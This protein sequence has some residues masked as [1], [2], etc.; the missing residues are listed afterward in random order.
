M[1][2]TEEE[3]L[4]ILE[5]APGPVPGKEIRKRLEFSEK[6]L[7]LCIE[8]LRALGYRVTYHAPSALSLDGRPDS[9]TPLEIRAGF[10]TLIVGKELCCFKEIDSTN[11]VAYELGLG[12]AKEGLAVVAEAQRRGRGRHG[13]RWE[14]PPGVNIY[15]SVVLRPPIST[16]VL[17]QMT[18]LVSLA[19]AQAI[20][21]T[22]GLA[23]RVKWPND[24]VV[25]GRK[26]GGVLLEANCQKE[27]VNFLVAGVGLNVN[28]G[29]DRF[30]DSIAARATSVQ[31][32]LKRPVSRA[33]LLRSLYRKLDGWYRAY[34]MDGFPPVWE[35]WEEL[36]DLKGRSVL[37]TAPR[38][39]LTA[40][41]LGLDET[42]RLLL[43][44]QHDRLT[45]LD[46]GDGIMVGPLE[47]GGDVP[48][49][50]C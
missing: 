1:R 26:I 10:S 33:E 29:A 41:V 42:G 4:S 14:S 37:V 31:V 40:F 13:R 23:A 43:R 16:T 15:T 18:I 3:L 21:D 7:R 25:G 27:A 48:S 11:D 50:S 39:Q 2:R 17:S 47:G 45:R 19:A 12:G 8:R 46:A 22:T 36:W 38:G 9:L 49:V 24:V 6:T 5:E 20:A 30:P 34:T 28:M 44:D 32:E 35:A